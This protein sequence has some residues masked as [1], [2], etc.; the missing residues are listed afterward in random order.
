[1]NLFYS[2]TTSSLPS[3]TLL[4]SRLYL[5]FYI[6]TESSKRLDFKSVV[7]NSREIS[8]FKSIFS[9]NSDFFKSRLIHPRASRP[10]LSSIFVFDG[11]QSFLQ[12][13]WGGRSLAHF[14]NTCERFEINSSAARDK[15]WW[16]SNPV[17]VG[18]VWTFAMSK[19]THNNTLP[20]VILIT[21]A[22]P[23]R[24][25]CD[26]KSAVSVVVSQVVSTTLLK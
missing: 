8:I 4:C 7:C 21:T 5:R 19:A 10:V 20:D 2:L 3:T 13:K 14:T 17:L 16:P 1:V 11:F 6:F 26:C 18:E 24:T 12:R 22:T 23:A 9:G 25:S 15:Y